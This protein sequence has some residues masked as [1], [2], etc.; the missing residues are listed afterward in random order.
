MRRAGAWTASTDWRAGSG[1]WGVGLTGTPLSTPGSPLPSSR[2]SKRAHLSR[3]CA[4][5]PCDGEY[6]TSSARERGVLWLNRLPTREGAG[7]RRREHQR[8]CKRNLRA[9]CERGDRADRP[10]HPCVV[11]GFECAEQRKCSRAALGW[12][13]LCA[14]AP[15]GIH[16]VQEIFLCGRNEIEHQRLVDSACSQGGRKDKPPRGCASRNLENLQSHQSGPRYET[17]AESVHDET[18][19]ISNKQLL[20]GEERRV[21][22]P[23]LGVGAPVQTGCATTDVGIE[24]RCQIDVTQ[25]VAGGGFLGMHQPKVR[26]ITDIPYVESEKDSVFLRRRQK[27]GRC[28]RQAEVLAQPVRLPEASSIQSGKGDVARISPCLHSPPG[29]IAADHIDPASWRVISGLVERHGDSVIAGARA[30]RAKRSHQQ[31]SVIHVRIQCAA[32]GIRPRKPEAREIAR[33]STDLSV[34]IRRARDESVTRPIERVATLAWPATLIDAASGWP[35]NNDHSLIC[36]DIRLE[37]HREI[38]ERCSGAEFMP[39]AGHA[40]DRRIPPDRERQRVVHRHYRRCCI[41]AESSGAN[42]NV[43]RTGGTTR[44]VPTTS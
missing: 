30:F 28:H 3:Q 10:A 12:E 16:G 36:P 23:G 44:G 37:S 15:S 9:R 14:R 32:S 21:V 39:P 35:R 17:R 2:H 31:L 8:D 6:G 25:S 13:K 26:M 22:I 20:V 29:A 18:L 27:G 38:V 4:E 19:V 41:S 11:R 40:G 42:G 34:V 1:E 43:Y 7:S 24:K 5:V 33:R